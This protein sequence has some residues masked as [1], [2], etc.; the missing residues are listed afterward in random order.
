MTLRSGLCV[1]GCIA[2]VNA[3]DFVTT[4]GVEFVVSGKPF[5]FVGTNCYYLLYS[6]PFMVDN[7][8]QKAALN[9]FT[10]LRTW[11]WLDIGFPNGTGS[12]DGG[13]SKNGVWFRAWDPDTQAVV[14]NQS[15]LVHL[16]AVVAAAKKWGIRLI[17]T[18]RGRSLYYSESMASPLFSAADKQLARL[19][20]VGS[21][22]SQNMREEDSAARSH[23]PTPLQMV[24]WATWADPSYTSPHHDDAF[25][26]SLVRGW[27]KDWVAA[28]AARVN[29]LTGVAYR[30]E[31]AILAW[32][33]AN[34]P[35]CYGSGVYPSTGNCTL[36]YAV[37]DV[38]PVVSRRGG[39]RPVARRGGEPWHTPLRLWCECSARVS[40][41]VYVLQMRHPARPLMTYSYRCYCCCCAGRR[42][43]SLAGSL[44]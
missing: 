26:S 22:G 24:R 39:S 36:N 31:P 19:W 41:G 11:A 10:V 13:G 6:D 3:A 1:L 42:G 7:A 14:T 17:L 44:R 23:A 40:C 12:V 18:V 8:F 4:Q 25:T 37:Y 16:D 38:Q 29:S 20:R 30:D 35:R 9:N 28:L 15:N 43:R 34:E 32:E 21:G 2:I 5:S 27:Y 33:L